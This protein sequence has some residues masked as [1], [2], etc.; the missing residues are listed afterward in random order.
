MIAKMEQAYS[1]K[2]NS[3]LSEDGQ[4][5]EMGLLVEPGIGGG[6]EMVQESRY[7]QQR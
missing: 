6:Q 3:E 5:K 2:L 7:C 1:R 4:G